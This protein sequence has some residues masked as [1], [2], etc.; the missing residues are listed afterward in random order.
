MRACK[1]LCR[2]NLLIA[3]VPGNAIDKTI[4]NSATDLAARLGCASITLDQPFGAASA[5]PYYCNEVPSDISINTL[6]PVSGSTRH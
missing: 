3:R 6:H 5:V 4:V 2:T 1:R